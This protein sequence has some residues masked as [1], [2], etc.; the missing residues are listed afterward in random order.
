MVTLPGFS[1]LSDC[2]VACRA[3]ASPWAGSSGLG[4]AGR[5]G[6]ASPPPS[7]RRRRGRLGGRSPRRPA[8]TVRWRLGRAAS[9]CG[10]RACRP[11]LLG[12]RLGGLGQQLL[13]LGQRAGA[14]AARDRAGDLLVLQRRQLA[15]AAGAQLLGRRLVGG[16][17]LQLRGRGP[18]PGV[19]AAGHVAAAL[20]VVQADELLLARL[21]HARAGIVGTVRVRAF[22]Q[23]ER[24]TPE[25]NPG[26]RAPRH[27]AGHGPR[28]QAIRQRETSKRHDEPSMVY[29]RLP[30][31]Q[32]ATRTVGDAVWAALRPDARRL[33]PHPA[34]PGCAAGGAC[35][36]RT[37]LTSCRLQK[38]RPW[39]SVRPRR[40]S[41]ILPPPCS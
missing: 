17:R 34:C 11:G 3:C 16:E 26:A 21:A 39:R 9:A 37:H 31:W 29:E 7:L 1:G 33:S 2:V 19:L 15:L 4:R 22:A 23:R 12:G 6:G 5:F 13:P 25:L 27:P 41:T 10:R 18:G 28:P 14:G 36:A 20:L 40:S 38:T 24:L 32:A 35:P 8:L 30:P